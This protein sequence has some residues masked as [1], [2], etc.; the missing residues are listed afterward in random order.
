M[1]T[2]QLIGTFMAVM[3]LLVLFGGFYWLLHR[4]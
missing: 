1:N 3:T 2:I 4:D